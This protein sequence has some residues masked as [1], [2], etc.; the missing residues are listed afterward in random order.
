MVRT[1]R[2]TKKGQTAA[3]T[4]SLEFIFNEESSRDKGREESMKCEGIKEG[5]WED[6]EEG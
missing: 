1:V 5:M 4:L 6:E 2:N 3:N